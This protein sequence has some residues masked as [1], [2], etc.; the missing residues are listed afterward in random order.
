MGGVTAH[1]SGLRQLNY[2]VG[3]SVYNN[4]ATTTRLPRVWS[5]QR[6]GLRT[7]TAYAFQHPESRDCPHTDQRGPCSEATPCR[8]ETL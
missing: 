7:G 1:R 3:L 4:L 6:R 2:A 5:R 8:C